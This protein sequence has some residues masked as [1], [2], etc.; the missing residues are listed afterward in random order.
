[1]IPPDTLAAI[2]ERLKGLAGPVKI[3]YFHQPDTKI[4]VRGRPPC[5]RCEPTHEL[6]QEIA[7]RSDQ[8]DLRVH[9]FFNDPKTA[10]KWGAERVPGIVIHGEINRPLRFYGFPGG[11]FLP[12][13]VDLLIASSA[14]PPAPPAELSALI[15]KLREPVRIRVFGS[16][17]HPPTALAARTAFGLSLVSDKITAATYLIEDNPDLVAQV[18]LTRIPLNLVNDKRGFAGVTTSVGLAQFCLD[19]QTDPDDA[20]P[21]TTAPKSFATL[22]A[23]PPPPGAGPPG[24]GPR[25]PGAG[26][27][28]AGPPGPRRTPGGLI[29][30]GQ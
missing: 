11:S 17:Q 2:D 3:D 18:K 27:P 29:L 13:I 26:P 25:P 5:P 8:I 6:L 21:P 7:G 15:K 30:P 23:A 22:Q 20:K 1:M 28:G 12:M 4:L 14:K 24:A 16:I 19:M 9:E 10:A